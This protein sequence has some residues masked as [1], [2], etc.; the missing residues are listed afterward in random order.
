MRKVSFQI[1]LFIIVL[2]LSQYSHVYA[3]SLWSGTRVSDS[4]YFVDARTKGRD[5]NDLV[6]I[7]ISESTIANVSSDQDFETETKIQGAF[8]SWFSID[9]WEDM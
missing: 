2:I 9:G 7:Y 8:E 3:D 6:F 1:A 4:S 5:V